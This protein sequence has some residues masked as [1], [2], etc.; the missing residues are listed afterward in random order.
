MWLDSPKLLSTIC[1][2]NYLY[3]RRWKRPLWVYTGKCGS[4][5]YIVFAFGWLHRT[6]QF[7]FMRGVT[8]SDITKL[9]EAVR[10]EL[11]KQ[12]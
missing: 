11:E 12:K 9:K 6:V 2:E 10:G 4:V 8:S 5:F 7:D 3:L 1:V